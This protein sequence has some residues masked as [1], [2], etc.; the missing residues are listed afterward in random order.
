V[1]GE[2]ETDTPS[3]KERFEEETDETEIGGEKSS[4]FGNFEEE[5]NKTEIA[6][7]KGRG[8]G[9]LKDGNLNRR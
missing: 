7:K 1:R 5:A 3:A 6:G 9:E 8:F 2:C 4:C